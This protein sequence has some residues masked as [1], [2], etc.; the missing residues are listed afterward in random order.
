METPNNS[1]FKYLAPSEHDAL[2]GTT[3]D[4]VGKYNIEPGYYSYP[5]QQD[6]RTI[7]TLM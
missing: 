3:V 1:S 2:W 5:P 6:I 4:T 7:I